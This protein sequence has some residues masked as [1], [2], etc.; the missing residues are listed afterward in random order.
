P[1]L[2]THIHLFT[3]SHL[4][5][6]AWM[7]DTNLLY[8]AHT[9]SEYAS[10]VPSSLAPS[11]RGFIFVETDCRYTDPD[12]PATASSS[13]LNEAWKY[14]LNEYEFVYN[15]S[16]T[17]CSEEIPVRGIVPWAPVHLGP[18]MLEKYLQKLNSIGGVI[19]D[20]VTGKIDKM[21]SVLKGFRYLLQD[22]PSGAMLKEKFIAGLKWVASKGLIF[23]IGIDIR[24]GGIWQMEEFVALL[25]KLGDNAPTLVISMS[26]PLARL[27]PPNGSLLHPD[28]LC[29][30]DFHI[31][32]LKL[33]KH[34]TYQAFS[35]LLP[36]IASHPTTVI[37][38]SGAFSE[39]P[40]LS[41]LQGT[42]P[43]NP[44]LQSLQTSPS[45]ILDRI[46]PWASIVF[47]L[48]TP[49]RL[50]W[51]SDWPICNIGYFEN[52]QDASKEVPMPG[53]GAWSA[54]VGLMEMLLEKLVED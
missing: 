41:T 49:R 20:P 42:T 7:A 19:V 5:I 12:V 54:W 9:P 50:I 39:L 16:K 51:G 34:P 22:K 14:V 30:P 47:K 1:I 10:C 45:E 21:K 15:I 13:D 53:G 26:F 17:P 31:P 25:E 29:K 2:D 43:S 11:H 40:P 52:H 48:F 32:P 6:L 8:R 46:Y 24:S 4:P 36:K 23:E 27:S 33:S 28:H 44:L 3:Q 37:K 38:L 18:E 35:T